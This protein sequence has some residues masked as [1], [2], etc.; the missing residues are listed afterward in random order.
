MSFHVIGKFSASMHKL[1]C[2]VKPNNWFFIILG[3]LK[4]FSE[5]FE[6]P[7]FQIFKNKSIELSSSS[8]DSFRTG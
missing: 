7:D 5:N 3:I 4:L 2:L 1:Q 6:S 8:K